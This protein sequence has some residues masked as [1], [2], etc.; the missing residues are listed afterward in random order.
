MKNQDL[1]MFPTW[2]LLLMS[3]A[4]A[5]ARLAT[6]RGHCVH[7]NVR[8]RLNIN[9]FSLN[10]VNYDIIALFCLCLSVCLFECLHA[11][12]FP[13]WLSRQHSDLGARL[14]DELLQVDLSQLLGQL[15]QLLLLLLRRTKIIQT[16]IFLH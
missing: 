13:R 2:G 3:S 15:L 10:A 8:S 7:T 12:V 1:K 11:V 14:L 6:T 4:H 5:E 9:L 16:E